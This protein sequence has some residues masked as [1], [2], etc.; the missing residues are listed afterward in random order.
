M[1]LVEINN[2]FIL[3][4]TSKIQRYVLGP[5]SLPYYHVVNHLFR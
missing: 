4:I 5:L 2:F 3:S 1:T